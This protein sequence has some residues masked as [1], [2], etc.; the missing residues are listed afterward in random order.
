MIPVEE[1]VARIVG[2]FRPLAA[3]SVPVSDA[4]GRVLAEDVLA[5]SSQPPAPVSSMD[6]Y[7]VRASDV[8]RA[9][10]SLTVIGSSPAGHPFEHTITSGDAVRIFT[11]GVVPEG[12]DAII[13]QEDAD[14]DGSRV[15]FR[16]VAKV[17]QHIRAAGRDHR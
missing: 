10:V 6:G 2:A 4:A 13:I 12:A 3:E 17:G 9:G 16:E 7:A 1:A 11:G 15:T 5:K 14:A 8:P